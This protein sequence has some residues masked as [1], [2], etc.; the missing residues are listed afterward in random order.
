MAI[1]NLELQK[2]RQE[3]THLDNHLRG[4]KTKLFNN[5]LVFFSESD[6]GKRDE[7]LNSFVSAK[8][9]LIALD[10][11]LDIIYR[12]TQN[13]AR[14]SADLRYGIVAD[15]RGNA[16]RLK[17]N[18]KIILSFIDDFLKAVGGSEKRIITWKAGEQI[19]EIIENHSKQAE[20]YQKLVASNEPMI[21]MPKSSQS[22][23]EGTFIVGIALTATLIK[24]FLERHGKS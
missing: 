16:E 11:E 9:N 8:H 4:L 10:K 21:Q 18:L 19:I 14:I 24:S 12:S 20:A 15:I 23:S 2:R 13:K 17:N 5:N 6:A 7:L 3:L 1:S 22:I